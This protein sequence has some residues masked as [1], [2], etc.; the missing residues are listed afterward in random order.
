MIR[1]LYEAK[2]QPI[3]GRYGDWRVIINNNPPVLIECQDATQ[4]LESVLKTY[5]P[6]Q[7]KNISLISVIAVNP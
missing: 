5:T 7:R 6:T 2:S 1:Y 3:D 4:A